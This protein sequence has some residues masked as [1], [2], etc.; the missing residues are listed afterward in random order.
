[1]Q[2]FEQTILEAQGWG[3]EDEVSK[4]YLRAALN[5]ELTDRLVT[6]D[7]PASYDDFV[8]Q[9]RKTSDKMEALRG[10]NNPRNSNRSSLQTPQVNENEVHGDPIDW[11]PAQPVNVAASQHLIAGRSKTPQANRAVW[12]SH[13]EIGRR[14]SEGLCI[15]CGAR[16]HRIREY[17]LLPAINPNRYKQTHQPKVI[18][19]SSSVDTVNES[20]V[21][22]K[23]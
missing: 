11:G 7:E 3:W 18:T 16:N 5:R 21:P 6:Q 12:V 8:A 20:G 17:S 1:M 4:G 10:W 13:E 15:R 2:D 23:E 9:L 19:S 14:I 22:G